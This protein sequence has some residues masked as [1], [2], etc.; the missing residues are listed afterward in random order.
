MISRRI[1]DI[2]MTIA[3]ML[4]MSSQVTGQEAH[5]YTGIAMFTLF[6]IHQYLNRRW[7]GAL[8]KGRYTLLRSLSTAVNFALL[9]SFITTAFSGII[10]SENFPSLNIESLTSFA[11]LAHLSC[12]YLSFTLMGIHLGLH[13]GIVAGKIKTSWPGIFAAILAGYGL[14]VFVWVNNVASYIFLVN[15]FAFLDY[16][17][18]PALVFLENVAMMSLWTLAGYQVSK[19][20]TG[21]FRRP[22]IIMGIALIAALAFRVVLGVP[23][24][25]F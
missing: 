10:M 20:L 23:E 25:G 21:K 3:L 9:V 22:A 4:Q 15:E 5:E 17:K 8:L 6:L 11:R 24:G 1:I 16:D 13:W 7:Y 14:Y 18:N 19:I 2:L 12:S